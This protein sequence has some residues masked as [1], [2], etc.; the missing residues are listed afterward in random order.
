MFSI[1]LYEMSIESLKNFTPNLRFICPMFSGDPFS[2]CM[3]VGFLELFTLIRRLLS[4]II[5]PLLRSNYKR[6][7]D[8][9]VANLGRANVVYTVAKT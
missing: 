4:E 1:D 6:A 5:M 3:M 8:F 9:M 7:S 2:M